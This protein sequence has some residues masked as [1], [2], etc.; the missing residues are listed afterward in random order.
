MKT[1]APNSA[2]R[3]A[4]E[5][6]ML[7]P[8]VDRF[9][10]ALSQRDVLT[11][12]EEQPIRRL[13]DGPRNIRLIAE[14]SRPRESCLIV[15]GYAARTNL[16]SS[17]KRQVSAVHVPG[18]FVDLHSLLLTT[19]DHG[20]VAI[21]HCLVVFIPH[22]YRRSITE[23]YLHLSRLLWLSTLI[24]AAIQRAWI[25]CLGRRSAAQHLAHLVCEIYQRLEFVGLAS[26]NTFEFPVTQTEL[27]DI[28]GLSNVPVNRIVQEL[29]R[30]GLIQ[31]QASRV[32]IQDSPH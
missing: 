2:R 10:R 7:E 26:G 6:V 13:L 21:S 8:G 18:N 12:D 19:M 27:G 28:L 1:D 20:V 17:G 16:L 31:W 11:A 23:T 3:R 22:A 15:E 30:S 5:S 25:T 9:I 24:D 14:G 4:I 29:R 32:K